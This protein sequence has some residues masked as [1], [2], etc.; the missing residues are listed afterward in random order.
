MLLDQGQDFRDGKSFVYL[1]V[2]GQLFRERVRRCRCEQDQDQ[3]V[4]ASSVNSTSLPH[5]GQV[6]RPANLKSIFTTVIAPPHFGHG[7]LQS[8]G[9]LR[10][11]PS[12]TSFPT[13]GLWIS[14]AGGGLSLCRVII[15]F[16]NRS[17]KSANSFRIFIRVM[18]SFS[19]SS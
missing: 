18:S 15:S 12:W 19:L 1:A 2:A 8:Q 6:Y 10:L 17:F 16:R 14:G 13:Y 11:Y 3:F 4:S 5:C 9:F 7:S